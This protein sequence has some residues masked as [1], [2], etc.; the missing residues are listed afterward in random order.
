M[1]NKSF[2]TLSTLPK[3]KKAFSLIDREFTREAHLFIHDEMNLP[4]FP[5]LA[6]LLND[7]LLAGFGDQDFRRT[8]MID[9]LRM[10]KTYLAKKE[11][12]NPGS[13]DRKMLDR[14]NTL[15][16]KYSPKDIAESYWVDIFD[17]VDDASLSPDGYV[18]FYRWNG[19]TDNHYSTEG[20]LISWNRAT[21]NGFPKDSPFYLEGPTAVV[22]M[23]DPSRIKSRCMKNRMKGD[24]LYLEEYCAMP[25]H[26]EM[27]Y[28]DGEYLKNP[29]KLGDKC[30]ALIDS[31]DVKKGEV[32][33]IKVVYTENMERYTLCV[34]D[35]N[36]GGERKGL[37]EKAELLPLKGR[38]PLEKIPD[39][40]CFITDETDYATLEKAASFFFNYP[41]FSFV[42]YLGKGKD[43]E[44]PYI[45]KE[46]IR[47]LPSALRKLK[48]FSHRSAADRQRI[49]IGIT[50]PRFGGWSK[51]SHGRG[52]SVIPWTTSAMSLRA[53]LGT[54]GSTS[55]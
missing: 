32:G 8:N 12:A 11:K 36:T 16:N 53:C 44:R 7:Y 3:T 26:W 4:D 42:A 6:L 1:Q 40:R 45:I 21:G 22:R 30:Q 43:G 31:F 47:N 2:S 20:Q 48:E 49:S 13:A 34:N 17:I 55:K 35:P 39:G 37:F 18:T 15:L 29:Y 25:D 27:F 33:T 28:G 10:A 46:R 24:L 9:N 5:S 38:K 41:A 19:G 14:I 51:P 23:K 50:L 54:G 52:N